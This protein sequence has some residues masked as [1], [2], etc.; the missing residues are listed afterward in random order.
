MRK[1]L[2]LAIVV[3]LGATVPAQAQQSSGAALNRGPGSGTPGAS[4][5]A[6][7]TTTYAT[8][9]AEP[10]EA[11]PGGGIPMGAAT[12]DTSNPPADPSNFGNGGSSNR[13]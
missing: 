13:R 8:P 11:V 6:T 12:Q 4:A 2:I 3:G 10:K 7:R 9:G 1:G 5:G